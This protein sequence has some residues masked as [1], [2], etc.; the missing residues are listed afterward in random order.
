MKEL[1]L[2]IILF[3]FVQIGYSQVTVVIELMVDGESTVTDDISFKG[4]DLEWTVTNMSS[5]CIVD[6]VEAYD[7]FTV[8]DGGVAAG[9]I[10]FLMI[11]M[12]VFDDCRSAI[13]GEVLVF[14]MKVVNPS[15]RFYG[16]TAKKSFIVPAGSLFD[17]VTGP[18]AINFTA[19]TR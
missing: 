8:V 15:H 18:D 9:G 6:H 4:S 12:N 19:P 10:S 1:L 7:K 16:Y 11:D 13:E 3:F 17:I 5:G 14:D 2:Y